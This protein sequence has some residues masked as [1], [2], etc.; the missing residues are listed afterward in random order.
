MKKILVQIIKGEKRILIP[1][2]ALSLALIF[3]FSIGS[4]SA[5]SGDVIYVNGSSGNDS[6]DGLSATWTSGTN[7]PKLSIKNATGTVDSGGT[8]SIANGK[9]TGDNNTKIIIAKNMKIIGQSQTGTVI[10][11]K[12]LSWIFQVQKGITVTIKNIK[13]VNG[14]GDNGGTIY[15][16][17]SLSISDSIFTDNNADVAGGA[18]YN[19]GKLSVSGSMF[20]GNSAFSSGGAI[21]NVGDLTLVDNNFTDNSACAAGGAVYNDGDLTI[22]SSDFMDNFAMAASGAIYNIGN[23]TV[24]NSN[25]V[26]NSALAAGGAIYNLWVMKVSGSSFINNFAYDAGGAVFNMGDLYVTKCIFTGN[27]AYYEG[28]AIYNEG[29]LIAAGTYFTHNVAYGAGDPKHVPTAGGAIYNDMEGK[30]IL[31]SCHFE[32]NIPQD[33]YD[34]HRSGNGS[35]DDPGVKVKAASKT[36]PLEKTGMPLAG[37]VLAILAV[38]C[39]LVPKRK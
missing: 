9:Y 31:K 13:F 16:N 5:A 28:G 25:F 17:G 6:W 36:I 32:G 21:Y 33:I 8:V 19:E 39:G 29:N 11:G 14:N 2:M 30:Y 27:E 18:V 10:D 37:L 4:V 3:N 26:N 1:L 35:S 12:N 20:T 23:L 15:N 34:V 38:F 22:L 7:G 24:T